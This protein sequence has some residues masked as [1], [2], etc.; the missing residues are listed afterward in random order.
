MKMTGLLS[1]KVAKG[2]GLN[3]AGMMVLALSAIFTWGCLTVPRPRD[4]TDYPDLMRDKVVDL[5]RALRG[6]PYRPGGDEI[7]GMDC[8]GFVH[9]VFHAFGY[10]APR[11][12]KA[13]AK[14][15]P[16]ISFNALRLADVLVFKVKRTWHVGIYSGK[17]RFVHAPSSGQNIREEVINEFWRDQLVRVV[18]IIKDR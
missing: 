14:Q 11:E 4:A 9:Y 16:A 12:A 3:R 13:F 18:R 7:D 15:K 5:A 8:S 6:R 17:N 2:P 1:R 10:S